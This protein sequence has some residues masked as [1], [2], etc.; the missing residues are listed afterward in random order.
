MTGTGVPVVGH[1]TSAV[2]RVGGRNYRPQKSVRNCRVC[3]SPYRFDVDEELT[4]GRVYRKIVEGLPEDANLSRDNIQRHFLNGH[5]SIE[6][7]VTRQ[8]VET[9]AAELG[10]RIEDEVGSVIDGITLARTVVEKTFARIAAGEIEPDVREGLAAVKL[11]A[12][13]GEYDEGGTDMAAMTEAFM[14]YHDNAQAYMTPEQFEA[15]GQ[16][17]ERNPV[18][19]AL[20]AKHEG[21]GDPV[22]GEAIESG[23]EPSDS[24][25]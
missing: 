25:A 7:A 2:V 4:A 21:R 6:S 24:Q 20:V 9:R 10:K 16:A 11:L 14:I 3:Q 5:L 15:F 19:A 1:N 17:L 13:Y 12:D 22:P 18:L 23:E 8:I